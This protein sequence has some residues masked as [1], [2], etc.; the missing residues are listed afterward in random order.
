MTQ[1]GLVRVVVSALKPVADNRHADASRQNTTSF[2]GQAYQEKTDGTGRK[3]EIIT[4]VVRQDRT[5]S[6]SVSQE[7]PSIALTSGGL[8]KHC[9]VPRLSD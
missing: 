8:Q 2:I 9:W 7:I 5:A 3:R 6:L 1:G 4:T